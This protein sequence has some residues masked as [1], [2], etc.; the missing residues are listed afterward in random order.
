MAQITVESRK[1]FEIKS[2]PY[3]DQAEEILKKEKEIQLLM[4]RDK[5]EIGYKK[6]GLVDDMIHMA[7]LYVGINSLAITIVQ[8]K[9]NEALNEAR[10][11]LYKAVIYL[12][13]IVSNLIDAPF[14][15]YSDKLEEISNITVEK[16]YAIVRKLG[17]AIRMVTDAYGD[18]TK[19]K[20]SFVEL[21]ARYATVSKNLMD[22]KNAIQAYI[23]PRDPDYQIA[24]PYLRLI[25]NLLDKAATGYRDKYELSTHRLDDMRLAIQYLLSLRRL[26]LLLGLTDEGENVK[27]K[28]VVW[29]SKMESD[30]KNGISQ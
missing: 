22:L 21:E 19:W 15:E 7:T 6:I 11:V 25:M 2:K 9:N 28:A 1:E 17:L 4:N 5:T 20:W 29:K 8:T 23:D 30:Q 13:E 24:V 16:K 10:K 27:K 14:S 3:R 12:E 18:N 26:Q